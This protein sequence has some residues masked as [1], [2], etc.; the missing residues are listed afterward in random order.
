ME[1]AEI[2]TAR[3]ISWWSI[4]KGEVR[5][6]SEWCVIHSPKRV[7]VLVTAA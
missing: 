3:G 1:A 7:R 2:T 5:Q 6:G 4:K